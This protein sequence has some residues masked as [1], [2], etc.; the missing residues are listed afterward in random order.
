MANTNRELAN[1]ENE[2]Q[3]LRKSRMQSNEKLKC[4]FTKGLIITL[5]PTSSGWP[6]TLIPS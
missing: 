6:L 4:Y 5:D 1:F 2:T 3:D